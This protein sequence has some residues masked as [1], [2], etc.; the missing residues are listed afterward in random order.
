ME[1]P[2]N[3]Y[4]FQLES[5]SI[6]VYPSRKVDPTFKELALEMTIYY[7]FVRKQPPIK[8]IEMLYDQTMMAIDSTVKKYMLFFDFI[9]VRGGTYHMEILP[10]ALSESL[11]EELNLISYI[12][13]PNIEYIEYIIQTY[14]RNPNI[15][16]SLEN[17]ILIETRT[18][19]SE[20]LEKYKNDRTIHNDIQS[21][22]VNNNRNDSDKGG[23][24]GSVGTGIET[25]IIDENVLTQIREL[26]QC[27]SDGG[28]I[29]DEISEIYPKLLIYL[30]RIYA[31]LIK[32][33]YDI[34]NGLDISFEEMVYI[35]NP[36]FGLD[37]FVYTKYLN[38][39]QT[40]THRNRGIQICQYYETM[41]QKV[42]N[43]I[44]ERTF[45]LQTYEPNL[46]WKYERAIYYINSVLEDKSAIS[47]I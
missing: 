34:P 23:G 5:N 25:Y 15:D 46:E 39:T 33:E 1:M 8:I 20:I 2:L 27:I 28:T 14:K 6:F 24:S 41:C 47:V 17:E 10:D 37:Y 16:I 45:D 38:K 9:Q 11:K 13:L 40:E 18:E 32:Y 3:I 26:K 42:L 43:M 22:I 29:S 4:V 7:E 31:I 12:D 30:K 36:E 19:I 44:D 35:K 21:F